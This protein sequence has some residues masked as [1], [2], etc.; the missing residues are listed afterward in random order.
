MRLLV[1]V[2]VAA[3]LPAAARGALP[4]PVTLDGFGGVVPGLT[5]RTVANRWGIRVA[6]A[7][8]DASCR[9]APIELGRLRGYAIFERGRLAAVFLR[10]GVRTGSG[11]GIGSTERRI[12]AVYPRAV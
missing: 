2:L 9:S 11:V 10:S 7:G 5:P 4:A 8:S 3:C 12:R 1:V 6:P